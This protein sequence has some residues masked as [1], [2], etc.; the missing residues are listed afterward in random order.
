MKPSE[1]TRIGKIIAAAQERVRQCVCR[2]GPA[3]AWHLAKAA[4]VVRKPKL[5]QRIAP[6]LEGEAAKEY[7][8]LLP[9]WIEQT[10]QQEAKCSQSWEQQRPDFAVQRDHLLAMLLR[11]DFSL[12]TYEKFARQAVKVLAEPDGEAVNEEIANR[13]TEEDCANLQ[14][15]IDADLQILDKARAELVAG[16]DDLVAKLVQKSIEKLPEPIDEITGYARCA[17][18]K[19]AENFDVRLGQRFATYAQWWIKTAITEKK[20]WE[21]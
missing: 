5:L 20:T 10:Q 7:L 16:H 19:A 13:M 1:E 11:Y 18:A 12:R 8:A 17:L 3:V 4:A 6:H 9:G 21:K 15:R 14:S 2:T